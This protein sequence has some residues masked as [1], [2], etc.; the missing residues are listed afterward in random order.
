LL[1]L[2]S[3]RREPCAL[4]FTTRFPTLYEELASGSLDGAA[5]ATALRAIDLDLH[6]T[7]PEHECFASG[8]PAGEAG[9]ASLRRVLRAYA[10]FDDQL[11]YCQRFTIQGGG[12]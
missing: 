12:G 5:A 3:P 10:A 4:R 2:I 9:V 8:T 11:G 1:A 6:R 7:F